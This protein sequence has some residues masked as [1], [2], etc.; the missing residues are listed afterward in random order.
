MFEVFVEFQCFRNGVS[1]G[2][3]RVFLECFFFGGQGEVV[4][5][6]FSVGISVLLAS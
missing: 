4:V 6:V 2:L 5:S 1:S 3:I